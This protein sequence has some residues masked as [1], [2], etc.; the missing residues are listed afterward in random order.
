V[1]F[2]DRSDL[3]H[4][5]LAAILLGSLAFPD[6]A[7]AQRA[8]VDVVA[9][10]GD[11]FGTTIGNEIVGVYNTDLLRGF[12]PITAGNI[13]INGLYFDQAGELNDRLL[14]GSTIRVGLTAQTYPF[15]AP[16][17]IVDYRLRMPGS[18]RVVS[19]VAGLSDFFGP[20]A[21][22]EMKL[23]VTGDKLGLAAGIGLA[24]EEH[25]DGSNAQIRTAA[26]LLNWH[27]IK[28]ATLT[29]FWSQLEGR[30]SEA[31]FDVRKPY[32]N[33]DAANVFTNLGEVANRG[34]ELS[35]AG[36]LVPRVK[37]IAGAVL[38]K[39]RVSGQAVELGRVG[40]KPINSSPQRI[41]A[42]L[43]YAPPLLEGLLLECG[44]EIDGPRIASRDNRLV[45]RRKHVLKA[46]MR[47]RFHVGRLQG[48]CA[49]TSRISRTI[50][51]GRSRIVADL[52]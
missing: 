6:S 33:L 28:R 39:A 29:P 22:M 11:A 5:P 16:T 7:Q 3:R 19:T 52:G 17:G 12:S 48:S 24:D 35:I 40:P 31:Q 18:K 45:L 50:S 26:L 36:K 14:D 23:P 46:G 2:L 38:L 1:L 49:C 44:A 27:P 21:E 10:A 15:P 25:A 43:E 20:Y 13:R 51:I 34:V 37:V 30:G 42:D 32:F 8:N 9:A 4:T 47:Y 41:R